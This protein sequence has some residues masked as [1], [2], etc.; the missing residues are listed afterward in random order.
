MKR[1]LAGRYSPRLAE[2]TGQHRAGDAM[3]IV[4][5]QPPGSAGMTALAM[6]RR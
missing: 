4:T 6:A 5:R 1:P 2:E 3:M